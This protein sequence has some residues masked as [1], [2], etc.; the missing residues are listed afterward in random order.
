[1]KQKQLV[2]DCSLLFTE[3]KVFYLKSLSIA[4]TGISIENRTQKHG[5]INGS[6]YPHILYTVIYCITYRLIQQMLYI[7]TFNSHTC[8][9]PRAQTFK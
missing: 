4:I 9:I 7:T 2:T 3:R 8:L 1:M 5:K 6:K